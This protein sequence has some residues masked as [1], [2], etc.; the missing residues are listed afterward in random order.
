MTLHD[1]FYQEC[2]V[3]FYGTDATLS[4]SM[5]AGEEI[6]IYTQREEIHN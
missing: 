3:F 6:L 2:S 4:V 5:A 1:L